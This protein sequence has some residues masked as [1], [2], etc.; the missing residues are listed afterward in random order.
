MAW[1]RVLVVEVIISGLLGYILKVETV[2]FDGLDEDMRKIDSRINV[3]F[4]A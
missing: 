2:E 1:T 3:K 4:L